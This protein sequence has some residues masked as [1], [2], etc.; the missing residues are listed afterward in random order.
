MQCRCC[1]ESSLQFVLNVHIAT[2]YAGLAPKQQVK[3]THPNMPYALEELAKK[4]VFN[5]ENVKKQTSR[6]KNVKSQKEREEPAK[7]RC[8]MTIVN[9]TYVMISH[10]LMFLSKHQQRTKL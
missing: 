2:T 5:A 9:L 4:I 10:G 3:V 7:Q 8:S 6:T 1:Y